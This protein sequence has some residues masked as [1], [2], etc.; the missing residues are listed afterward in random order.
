M[1]NT[2]KEFDITFVHTGEVHVATFES[3]IKS[4]NSILKVNHIVNSELLE[5]AMNHYP[6]N[7][8]QDDIHTVMQLAAKSSRRVVCTCSSIG[9][10]AET[11][12]NVMKD[13]VI[14]IDRAMAT[15]AIDIGGKV[16]VVAALK[17]TLTPTLDLLNDISKTSDNQVTFDVLCVEEAWNHFTAGDNEAYIQTIADAI[18]SY[19]DQFDVIVL[20]QASM[21]QVSERMNETLI[22]ILSSPYLGVESIVRALKSS[23]V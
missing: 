19:N 12:P 2:E 13:Q 22:P 23:S 5:K 21:A 9:A 4:M 11:T 16:L 1:M 7:D 15:K 20:A 8:L 17:S 3:L 6:I 10:I 14:R 18:Q